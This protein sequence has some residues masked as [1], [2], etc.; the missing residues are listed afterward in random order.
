MTICEAEAAIVRECARRVL[1][2]EPIRSVARDLNTRGVPT[3]AGK[4]WTAQTLKRTMVSGRISG[5]REHQPRPRT[6]TKRKIAG[7]IIAPA[8]WPA[9]IS[10]QETTR[11][12]AILLDPSRRL[13]NIVPKRCLLTGILRCSQC[14]AGL[15]GRPNERGQMRYVCNKVPRST[16]C[17][18]TY[19]MTEPADE[20]VT[21]ML[22]IA[23]D[24][25]ALLAA[26]QRVGGK[27]DDLSLHEQ[28]S[29]LQ[30]KLEE[31]AEDYASDAI[32]R[33]EWLAARKWLE[34]RQDALRRQLA[35][36]SQTAAL[37]GLYGDSA[38]F[39][40]AWESRSLHQRRAA[41]AAVLDRVIVK[42]A[43]RGRNTFD[44]DRF[45]PVWR[46]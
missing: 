2:G 38:A 14:M 43:V 4:Q 45:Q 13:T 26:L 24:S 25:P 30:H 36:T 20:L 35:A 34:A 3:A 19:V 21:D 23:L 11:L 32:T 29:A 5:Q 16:R 12:R 40:R 7:E 6:Q 22:R 1:A 39:Q 10:P 8:V 18:K 28:L 46:V 41:I 44:R 15:L 31:L 37:E 42:P 9:I 27:D 33:G 17:G